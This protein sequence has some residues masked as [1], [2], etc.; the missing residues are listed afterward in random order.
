MSYKLSPSRLNLFF[1]CERCF[2]LRVNE[3]VERPS[4]PFPSLPSGMDREIKNHFDRFRSKN[5]TP[6]EIKDA[7][8]EARPLND[9]NFLEKARSWRTEPKWRDHATGAVE[10]RC[11]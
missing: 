5:E 1:E 6:P 2:W 3:G 9:R 10:G 7:D 8:I 11:R 4:G